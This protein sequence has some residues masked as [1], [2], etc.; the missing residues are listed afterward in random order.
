MK[1]NYSLLYKVVQLTV[2]IVSEIT[3]RHKYRWHVITENYI[4]LYVYISE[5]IRIRNI[6]VNIAQ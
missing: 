6:H 2:I 4:K 3:Q 5:G 1:C